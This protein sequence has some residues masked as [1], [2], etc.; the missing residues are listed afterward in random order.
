M[1]PKREAGSGSGDGAGD[2]PAEMNALQLHDL[3]AEKGKSLFLNDFKNFMLGQVMPKTQDES[4]VT[5]APK[6]LKDETHIVWRNTAITL[7]NRVRG[8]YMGPQ[9]WTKLQDKTYKILKT[10]V[11][12]HS[13]KAGEVLEVHEDFFVVGTGRGS[14][15]VWELQPESKKKMPT[16]E[17]LR[18]FAL[19]KGDTFA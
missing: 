13:G 9:A 7:H 2:G 16:S 3:L 12:S 14:L 4:L 11:A 17:F 5:I 10:K 8:L 15:E 19:K 18:G 6:I 1:G